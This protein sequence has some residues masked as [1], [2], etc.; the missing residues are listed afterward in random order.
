[1][2]KQAKFENRKLADLVSWANNPRSILKEDFERLKKQVESLGVYKTLLVNQD[3]IVLGGNMRLRAFLEL[4]DP[5][6][7]ILC[8]IVETADESQMLAYAISDND[9]VGITDQQALAELATLNPI[10]TKLYAVQTGKLKPMEQ[11]LTDFSPDG[12]KESERICD[13]CG[14]PIRSKA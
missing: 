11:V 4:F 9:Q 6:T 7:E 13:C 2:I 1:M 8:G 10:D 3:N 5:Q 14:Q 12:D